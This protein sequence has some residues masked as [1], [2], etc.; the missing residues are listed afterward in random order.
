MKKARVLA[1]CMVCLL[2]LALGAFAGCEMERV[3]Y[4]VTFSQDGEV[5]KEFTLRQDEL[6]PENELPGDPQRPGYAFDGWF[7]GEVQFDPAQPVNRDAAFEAKFTQLFDLTFVADGETVAEFTD[8]RAGATIPTAN[9]PADPVKEGYAFDGWFNGE[10][11]FDFTA[12]VTAGGTYEA[13]FTQ[14]FTV[15]FVN[16]EETVASFSVR[17]GET[18]PADSIPGDLPSTEEFQFVGWFSGETEFDDLAPVTDNVVYSARFERIA[19]ALTFGETVVYVPVSDPVLSA[20]DIPGAPAGNGVFLGWYCDGV[21]AEAGIT[22]TENAAYEAVFVTEADYLGVWADTEAHIAVIVTED[23]VTFGEDEL[24]DV[25]FT[26]D[27]ETGSMTFDN[28]SYYTDTYTLTAVGDTLTLSHDYYDTMY[29]EMVSETYQLTRCGTFELAGS[30]LNGTTGLVVLDGGILASFGS[31]DRYGRLYQEDGAWKLEYYANSY[32]TTLTVLD[33]TVDGR[34]NLVIA[35]ASSESENGIYV[36]ADS[37]AR[38]EYYVS[39]VGSRFLYAYQTAEGTVYVWRDYDNV[40]SYAE[41]TGIV[42]EG[43]IITISVGD[44]SMIARITGSDNFVLAGS[45]RGTYTGAAG[46]L[47]LDGFGTAVLGEEEIAYTLAGSIAILDQTGYVLDFEKHTYT[48]ASAVEGGVSGRFLLDGSTSYSVT[49]YD[50]GVL[51]FV[52]TSSWSGDTLY[53]GTYTVADGQ[54]VVEDV[55]YN[56]DGS[57]Q[58]QEDGNVLTEVGGDAVYVKEGYEVVSQLENF[59]GWFVDE[60]GNYVSF[61]TALGMVTYRGQTTAFSAN[62]NGSVL[63]FTAV[64]EGSPIEGSEPEFTATVSGETLT[65]TFDRMIEWDDVYEEYIT[66]PVTETYTATEEP[67]IELDAFAG[68]WVDANDNTYLFDGQGSVVYD[69]GDSSETYA[70]T[71]NEEGNVASFGDSYVSFTCTLTSATTMSVYYDDGEVPFP[72]TA[73]FVE[74]DAFAGSWMCEEDDYQYV[75]QFDGYGT[76]TVTSL[77][78][79]DSSWYNGTGSYSVS[80]N[81]VTFSVVDYDWTCTLNEDGTLT[82]TT[83]DS[84]GYS[85]PGGTFTNMDAEEEPAGDAFQGTWVDGNNNTYVFDGQSSVSYNGD[86][87]S[88]TINDSGA[89][90]FYNDYYTITCTLNEDGSM[91]ANFQDDYGDENF[92]QTATKQ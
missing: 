4:T 66:E 71:L 69:T 40:Q 34:G 16:G 17:A 49:F 42:A 85:G 64:D 7:D 13:V 5:L 46:E 1:L 53:P 20:E 14:L 10:T 80:G 22:V 60:G 32:T 61:N 59:E 24:F 15:A 67:V 56:I 79:P 26:F 31:S 70:Y 81:V 28:G 57:W 33:V 87:Y 47:T 27:F 12:P 23:G 77:S 45:E 54:I 90:V 44:Q 89:A 50:F 58:V 83:S 30:Y 76:I 92:N 82:V 11:R 19:F 63:T 29:E 62:Y 88:Y 75:L 86:T 8:V 36:E 21:K 73:T 48:A 74:K 91:N 25:E 65:I 68:K 6:I 18:V 43:E 39:E 2:A 52:Y 35:G 72:T 37:C 55:Y 41:I 3:S 9:I 38:Y 84:D 51:I 78:Y